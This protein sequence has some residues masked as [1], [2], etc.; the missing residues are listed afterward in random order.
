MPLVELRCYPGAQL[1]KWI[2]VLAFVLDFDI[3]EYGSKVEAAL[4][5]VDA[6]VGRLQ[7]VFARLEHFLLEVE[8]DG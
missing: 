8:A 2:S 6:G 1:D 5:L 7:A 3:H 4:D